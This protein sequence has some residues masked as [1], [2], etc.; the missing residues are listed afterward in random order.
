[1]YRQDL[2][3]IADEKNLAAHVHDIAPS[4]A[5]YLRKIGVTAVTNRTPGWI[6]GL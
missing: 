4:T 3:R 5:S 6:R 1:M 2:D